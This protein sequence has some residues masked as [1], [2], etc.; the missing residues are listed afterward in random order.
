MVLLIL[1]ISMAG[2][3]KFFNGTRP[4]LLF[5]ANY[6]GLNALTCL[7]KNI[8]TEKSVLLSGNLVLRCILDTNAMSGSMLTQ[9]GKAV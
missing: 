2:E 3:K 9:Y 8:S 6:M 4:S 5:V 7:K 1:R